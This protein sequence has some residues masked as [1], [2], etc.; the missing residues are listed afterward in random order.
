VKKWN[1]AAVHELYMFRILHKLHLDWMGGT[2]S[3]KK[4]GVI[5]D[6]SSP[7]KYMRMKEDSLPVTE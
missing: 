7:R 2:I 5:S 4:L 6:N 3:T 1:K